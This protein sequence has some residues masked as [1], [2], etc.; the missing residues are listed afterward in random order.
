MIGR[1]YGSEF[2]PVTFLQF[3]LCAGIGLAFPPACAANPSVTSPDGTVQFELLGARAQLSFQ[4]SLD[5]ETVVEPS[6]FSMQLDG[7]DLSRDVSIGDVETYEIDKRYRWNGA[8]SEAINRC[9]CAKVELTHESSGTRYLLEVRVFDDGV[10][11]RHIIPG[12]GWRTPDEQSRFQLPTGSTVWYHD[13]HMHYET[14]HARNIV[15]DVPVDTWAAPPLTAKLPNGTGY[16]SITEGGL[17]NY[18]GMGLQADGKRGVVIRLGHAQPVNYPFE[19]RYGDAEAE[20]LQQP[21]AIDG[22][23]TTPWR[24]VMVG[25]DLN[26]L[27]NCGIVNHVAEPPDPAL[28]PDGVATEWLK[29]GRCLWRYLDGGDSSIAGQE[30]FSRWAGEL[31]FEYNLLEGYWR[32]WS[33]EELR[34]YVDF[35]RQHGVGVWVWLHS[36][37]LRTPEDRDEMFRRC[38]DAGVVGVKIDFLDHEAKEIIDLYHALLEETARHQLMVNFHGA[39][40]PAGEAR[41]WPNEMTREAVRGMEASRMQHRALHDATLPFTRYLAGHADY[42]AVHFGDRRQDTTWTH[43]IATAVVF[44]SPLL[45]YGAHPQS[46]LDNPAVEVIKSIP[47]TWDETVALPASDIGRIAAFARRKGDDWFLAIVSGP[48]SQTL[49]IPLTFLSD[50]TYEVTLVS[51]EADDTAAVN[52]EHMSATQANSLDVELA[53]GGGVVGRFVRQ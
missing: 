48:Q 41:T 22:E 40:K 34:D 43:Q 52:V 47:S 7:V 32:R 3:L 35:S 39:N 46:L 1:F 30:D 50:G 8:S 51:D 53:A 21:V 10:A 23:I 31:G 18:A 38:R 37:N 49:T 33:R 16:I 19:L 5:G 13:F 26:A 17:A 44:T 29:P 42:T 11:Y 6:E 20:R 24:V 28:F 36:R 9:R 15:D 2:G 14:A 45:V 12:D 25:R 4:I 27:V